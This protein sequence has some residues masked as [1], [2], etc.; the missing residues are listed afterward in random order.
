MADR[1]FLNT[2]GVESFQQVN[3]NCDYFFFRN[4]TF[5]NYTFSLFLPGTKRWSWRTLVRWS[6][7]QYKGT[8]NPAVQSIKYAQLL[9]IP[10]ISND[11]FETSQGQRIFNSSS[12][13]RFWRVTSCNTW[14]LL[15]GRPSKCQVL[16]HELQKKL[17]QRAHNTRAFLLRNYCYLWKG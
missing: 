11:R 15:L 8:S 3:V 2:E 10:I 4:V 17:S 5:T 12:M 1:F 7:Q 13:V 9:G 14:N 6:S 16:E